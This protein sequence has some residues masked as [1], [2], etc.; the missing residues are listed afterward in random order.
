M[1]NLMKIGKINI[2]IMGLMGSGKS[3]IGK[4]LSKIYKLKFVDTL[5]GNAVDWWNEI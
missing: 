3:S 2:S 1:V 5:H 4:E